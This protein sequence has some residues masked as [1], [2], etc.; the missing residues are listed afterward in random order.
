MYLMDSGQVTL[1]PER[2]F[3]FHQLKWA[4]NSYH[5]ELEMHGL[6][7]LFHPQHLEDYKEP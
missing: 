6:Q 1:E 5:S 4:S 3:S 7:T 2:A